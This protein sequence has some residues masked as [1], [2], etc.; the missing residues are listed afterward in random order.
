MRRKAIG[1]ARITVP[2]VVI[3]CLMNGLVGHNDSHFVVA[4]EAKQWQENWWV[5]GECLSF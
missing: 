5:G 4:S 2:N 3:N 1:L